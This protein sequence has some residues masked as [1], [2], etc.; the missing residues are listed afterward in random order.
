M[1]PH[2]L[3]MPFVVGCKSQYSKKYSNR[4][5][6]FLRFE[7]RPVPAIVENNKKSYQKTGSQHNQESRKPI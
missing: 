7:E 6:G 1:V 5:I 2:M 3:V 4:T